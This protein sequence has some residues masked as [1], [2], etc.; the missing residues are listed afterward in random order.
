[1]KGIILAGGR[2]TRLSP[3]TRVITKQ[4]L[5]VYNKPMI[6]Y[7]FSVLLLAGIRD[8]MIIGAPESKP[9]YEQL[10]G[11]GSSLG[12]RIS[13]GIQDAPRGIA[14]AFLVAS[15]FIASEP[16]ALILGDNIF[17]GH[18]FSERLNKAAAL[19]HGARVFGYHVK[20]PQ[21][22]GVID[23]DKDGRVLSIQEKPSKPRSNWA[24]TGLYFYDGDVVN[25]A[26]SI[27]PSSRGELEITDVNNV[28]RERGSLSVEL[29]GRGFAWLD[30]GTYDSLLDA[31]SF[32]RTFEER[33]SL[34]IGCI[35][36][37][38][39]RQGYIDREQLL[40]LGAGMRTSY[41]EYLERIAKEE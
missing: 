27:R 6:Y 11:D 16:V 17:Y 4:L 41:G 25:V 38:A 24:V 19:T 5:P 39:Y 35:E 18:G 34:H 2:A 12:V 3:V 7:P 23:L 1:M 33:Q 31:S 21:R 28:Y 14:D 29:L 8:I 20:D 26:R 37:I 10:F 9:L 40:R 30:T 22:Y 36:E 13:Y 15:D 32:I